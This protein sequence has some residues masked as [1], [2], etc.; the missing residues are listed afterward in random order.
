M[1]HS[2]KHPLAGSIVVITEGEFKGEKYRIEDWWDRL[3]GES[4]MYS[5]GNPA[6]MEYGIRSSGIGH[7]GDRS[8]MNDEVVYGKIGGLG[9]LMHVSKLGEKVKA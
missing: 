6:A 3:T 7:P 4:W 9:K 5:N 1:K 8:P 2:E